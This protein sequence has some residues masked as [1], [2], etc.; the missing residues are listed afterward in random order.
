MIVHGDGGRAVA[1]RTQVVRRAVAGGASVV[2]TASQTA[3][4]MHARVAST[5]S[6]VFVDLG[7]S[8]AMM[9]DR[10]GERLL[11]RLAGSPGIRPRLIACAT[12]GTPIVIAGARAAGA[13]AFVATDDPNLLSAVTAIVDGQA[14]WPAG[15]TARHD[16][17]PPPSYPVATLQTA[18]ATL[19]QAA[20]ALGEPSLRAATQ[21]GRK[22]IGLILELDDLIR[23]RR[24]HD[25]GVRAPSSDRPRDERRW[26]VLEHAK[27]HGVTD[28]EE[29]EPAVARSL[30]HLE[31]SLVAVADALRDELYHPQARA[32]LAL[33]LLEPADAWRIEGVTVDPAGHLTWRGLDAQRLAADAGAPVGDL[34]ALWQSIDAL[35]TDREISQQ[36]AI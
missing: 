31:D 1:E 5:S 32:A 33:S 27:A 34:R 15:V 23:N 9:L 28:E 30:S 25:D 22:D 13:D 4:V 18:T 16:P 10:P 24:R 14:V 26:A 11:R 7:G 6:C 3:V 19:H 17:P 36:R 2:E 12:A 8:D 35:L 29:L 21:L 20:R